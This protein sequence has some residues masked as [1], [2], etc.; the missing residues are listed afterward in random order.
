MLVL[1]L[2]LLGDSPQQQHEPHSLTLQTAGIHQLALLLQPVHHLMF[3][4]PV[5]RGILM[6]LVHEVHHFPVSVHPP[7]VLCHSRNLFCLQ[8]MSAILPEFDAVDNVL[9][10]HIAARADGGH[11]IEIGVG[12]PDGEGGVLLEQG[13]PAVDLIA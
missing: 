8:M 4:R 12:H 1:V 5:L 10:E 11:G 2:I 13:L 6:V 9:P 3:I 7:L